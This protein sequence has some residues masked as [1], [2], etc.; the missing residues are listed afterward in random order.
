M[1]I[2]DLTALQPQTNAPSH[3]G[4]KFA[5]IVLERILERRIPIVCIY[6]SNRYINPTIIQKLNKINIQVFNI[7]DN[8]LDYITSQVEN[9]LIFSILPK[10]SYLKYKTIGT[11]HDC[12]EACLP[13]DFNRF[14]LKFSFEDL[15]E[16]LIQK[17]M[18]GLQS[19]RRAKRQY[20]MLNNPNFIPTTISLF[21]KM[22]LYD[23]F[24]TDSILSMP[25]FITPS[26]Y[27]PIKDF[28]NIHNNRY[29]LMVSPNR[30]I[31]NP[32]RA[33]QAMDRVFDNER[34][35]DFKFVVVGLKGLR[36]IKIKVKNI[37]NFVFK[38]YVSEK[39]LEELYRN[40]TCLLF[41]S[42]YEGFGMPPL[43]AMCYGK[44]VAASSYS[45]IPEVCGDGALYFN[46][47]STADIKRCIMSLLIDEDFYQECASKALNRFKYIY[48]KQSTD[49]DKYIDFVVLHDNDNKQHH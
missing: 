8:S 37:D 17:L 1:I 44:P 16:Y 3:G 42:L 35:S 12:R 38:D 7:A 48:Q 25:I 47:Y 22:V 34:F 18:P 20:R 46:P 39:E 21:T 45:A 31:K 23:I 30:W 29:I 15:K 24:K 32:I 10:V 11:I 49:L 13:V 9:P 33:I 43:E 14:L 40:C 36:D 41:P 2:Y 4:G 26:Y 19:K 6:D 27:K 5:E 28:E